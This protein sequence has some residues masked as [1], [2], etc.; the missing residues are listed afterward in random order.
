MLGTKH[1]LGGN[2]VPSLDSFMVLKGME[3]GFYLACFFIR[4][5]RVN[6]LNP[7]S[8]FVGD[9]FI[10]PEVRTFVNSGTGNVH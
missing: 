6:P 5:I 8:L 9:G 10:R 2:V 4:A 1:Q 3:R 7:N